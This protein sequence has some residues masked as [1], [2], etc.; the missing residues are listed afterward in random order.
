M[1]AEMEASESIEPIEALFDR[2]TRKRL[3]ETVEGGPDDLSTNAKHVEG[4]GE[5]PSTND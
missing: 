3:L 2:L 1:N 5:S 4:F